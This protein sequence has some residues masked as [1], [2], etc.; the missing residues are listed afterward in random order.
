MPL[1]TSFGCGRVF[2]DGAEGRDQTTAERWT[3]AIVVGSVGLAF[4]VFAVSSI[5]GSVKTAQG[6]SAVRRGADTIR[7]H[8]TAIGVTGHT[9]TT[10][11]SAENYQFG[12]RRAQRVV[13]TLQDE[14]VRASYLFVERHGDGDLLVA[15]GPRTAEPLN[16]R[17]EAIVR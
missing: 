9:D 4:Q 17:V 12:L 16:R 15:T 13:R 11:D 8:S 14:G 2:D 1:L 10:G 7:V 3:A 6:A 5:A